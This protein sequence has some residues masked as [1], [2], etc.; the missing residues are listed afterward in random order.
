[1][2]QGHGDSRDQT[3]PLL[4]QPLPPGCGCH[5]YP[6]FPV[7]SPL[8]DTVRGAVAPVGC[9]AVSQPTASAKTPLQC[10][11]AVGVLAPLPSPHA[12]WH[13]HLPPV[14]GSNLKPTPIAPNPSAGP[15]S[16]PALRPHVPGEPCAVSRSPAPPPQLAT[17]SLAPGTRV[18]TG[19]GATAHTR[20]TRRSHSPSRG[21]DG[22]RHCNMLLWGRIQADCRAGGAGTHP[23]WQHP[24]GTAV[25]PFLPPSPAA[26]SAPMAAGWWPGHVPVPIPVPVRAAGSVAVIH[27]RSARMAA[28][29][30]MRQERKLATV[31]FLQSRRDGSGG[32]KGVSPLET[33]GQASV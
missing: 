13:C 29:F 21:W 22:T 11:L 7:P 8:A 1:M 12:G 10:S 33:R 27:C 16:I 14:P 24:S 26:P 18:A 23:A 6:V 25:P 31:C 19:L 2:G 32:P 15:V 17:P 9:P 28:A 30:S 4:L 3:S 20:G 5:C